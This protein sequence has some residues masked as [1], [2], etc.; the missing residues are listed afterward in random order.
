MYVF[1]CCIYKSRIAICLNPVE[2]T[3]T[4]GI[5]LGFG[6]ERLDAVREIN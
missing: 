1:V 6:A 3:R 4:V 5:S 2:G